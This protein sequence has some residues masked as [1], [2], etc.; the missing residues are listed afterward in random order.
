MNIL[1]KKLLKF[2]IVGL[3]KSSW[4]SSGKIIYEIEKLT[5]SHNDKKWYSIFMCTSEDLKGSLDLWYYYKIS[6]KNK[7]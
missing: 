1:S 3:I 4:N 5:V 6:T 2:L 7:Y